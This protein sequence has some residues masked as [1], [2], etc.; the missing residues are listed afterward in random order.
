MDIFRI[1]GWREIDD[2]LQQVMCLL[3][4]FVLAAA[5]K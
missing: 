5:G 1:Y 2:L 3:F 4:D